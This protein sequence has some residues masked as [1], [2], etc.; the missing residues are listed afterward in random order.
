MS[1][2]K[3]RQSTG[4]VFS[5][6]IYIF[7]IITT[8]VNGYI[9]SQNLMEIL[10]DIIVSF[11]GV[12]IFTGFFKRNDYDIV[13]SKS[14]VR[15]LLILFIVSEALIVAQNYIF[16]GTLWLAA[17]EYLS[18]KSDIKYALASYALHL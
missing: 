17:A 11:I 5:A 14:S 2:D 15:W 9:C 4:L 6:L 3:Q 18:Q 10:S 8:I 13:L 16:T 1:E 7:V 12:Y